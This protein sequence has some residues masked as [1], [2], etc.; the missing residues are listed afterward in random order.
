MI[1][2]K[3]QKAAFNREYLVLDAEVVDGRKV[4]AMLLDVRG[5]AAIGAGNTAE[6]WNEH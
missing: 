3:E 1:Q 4:I 6:S 5:Y 2:L